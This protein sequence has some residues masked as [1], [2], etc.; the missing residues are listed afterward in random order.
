MKLNSLFIVLAL[1]FAGFVQA[2]ELSMGEA[3]NKAGRQRMLTQK[4]T[5]CYMMIGSKVKVDAARAEL[6]AAMALFEE[7]F[8]E[9]E[10]FAPSS[11]V[12]E[13]LAE[14]SEL[15]HPFRIKVIGD[16]EVR[17]AS[18]LIDESTE[19]LGKCND[20]VVSLEEHAKLKAARLVNI[21]GRQRMLSQR[22]AM[23]YMAYAWEVPNTGIYKNL[24][25]AQKEFEEA[26]SELSASKLNTKQIN[27]G[28]AKVNAQWDFS[29]MT[30]DVKKSRLM[31]SVIS[32]TTNSMLKKMNDI[33]GMYSSVFDKQ[34]Y[35]RT[36]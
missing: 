20:V 27:E 34:K 23:L 7:Q 6:D 5:K 36:R 13:K 2:Q 12:E 15:W 21:S 8:L 18:E 29:K 25:Q 30:F 24:L 26:L 14:V 11:E 9:L 10:E 19:L 22:I 32:V 16:P 4:M 17:A 1:L 28:L 33:T 3:I 35:A 31:P